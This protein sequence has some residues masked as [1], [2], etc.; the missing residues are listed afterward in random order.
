MNEKRRLSRRRMIQ[1]GLAATGL[2]AF[3][4]FS[5]AMRP[6]STLPTGRATF[7]TGEVAGLGYPFELPKLPHG[8]SAFAPGIDKATMEIHHGKH[9]AGYVRKLNA[10]LEKEPAWQNK[11]LGELLSAIDRLPESIRTAVR[12]NGGG[13]ANHTLYWSTMKPGGSKPT[14]R[15]AA[16]VERTFGGLAPLCE[17]L[18]AAALGRF[19]SGWAWL[20]MA[21]DGAL[22]VTSTPNQ[23][24]PMMEGAQPL[25]GI[26]VWEHAYYL[27]YQNRRGDYVDAFLEIADWSAVSAKFAESAS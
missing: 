18:K 8:T 20:V 13:H 2:L 27:N 3:P 25:F 21:P 23:D 1:T 17:A 16:E 11:T 7:S 24:S 6:S 10:A 15:F 9:H 19:G 26:D 5:R 4:G 14:G 12:Q 22:E